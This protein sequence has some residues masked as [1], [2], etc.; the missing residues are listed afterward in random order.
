MGG[1]E[2]R[3][4]V[5]RE[6]ATRRRS[7]GARASASPARLPRSNPQIAVAVVQALADFTSRLDAQLLAEGIETARGVGYRLR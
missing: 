3:T 7:A 5:K 6:T 1:K 2:T 4:A